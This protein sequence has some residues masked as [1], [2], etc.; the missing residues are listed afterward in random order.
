MVESLNLE[1]V[2]GNVVPNR[3]REDRA[4]PFF[5]EFI[6]PFHAVVLAHI[7]TGSVGLVAFWVPV[8]AKK[9]GAAHRAWGKVFTASMLVTGAIAL[10]RHPAAGGG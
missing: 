5:H 3:R 4:L 7:V 10:S 8:L 1:V 2:V 9:G 6:W